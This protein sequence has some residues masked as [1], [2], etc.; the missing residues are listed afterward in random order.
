MIC[1][2]QL[3]VHNCRIN[4]IFGLLRFAKVYTLFSR[5]GQ[6]IVMF[7]FLPKSL[8]LQLHQIFQVFKL[9]LRLKKAFGGIIGRQ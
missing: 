7:A 3:F 6:L 4:K 8:P 1:E 2:L 9:G 5:S